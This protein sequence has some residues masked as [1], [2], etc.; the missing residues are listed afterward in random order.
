MYLRIIINTV[1][2]F[3]TDLAVTLQRRISIAIQE[4]IPLRR[5]PQRGVM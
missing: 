3:I 5:M 1:L 2:G 4:I